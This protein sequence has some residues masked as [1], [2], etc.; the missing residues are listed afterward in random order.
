VHTDDVTD[1]EMLRGDETRE[2]FA[3]LECRRRGA[4]F[5]KIE[6]ISLKE[7]A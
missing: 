7:C 1:I 5:G 2:L 6:K 3:S 4:D